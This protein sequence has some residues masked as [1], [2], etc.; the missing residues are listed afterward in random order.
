MGQVHYGRFPLGVFGD[1]TPT[2][3]IIVLK[4]ILALDDTRVIEIIKA[5]QL[6]IARVRDGVSIDCSNN[7]LLE[8]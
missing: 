3:T 8:K 6:L 2:G 7:V 5:K 4:H 1:K